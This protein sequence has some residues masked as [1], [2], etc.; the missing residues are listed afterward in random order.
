[1][2]PGIGFLRDIKN[3]LRDF[4]FRGLKIKM[5]FLYCLIGLSIAIAGNAQTSSTV[6]AYKHTST[7]IKTAGAGIGTGTEA[8]FTCSPEK[9]MVGEEITFD[10]SSSSYDP[11]RRIISYEWDFG[12]GNTASYQIVFHTYSK[13]GKYNITLAVTDDNG[14]TNDELIT[15]EVKGKE[16]MI[17]FDDG[18]GP[19][20][21]PYILDQLK[22]IK[23]ADGTPVK[24]G[25]FLVGQDKSRTAYWDIWKCTFWRL[26]PWWPADMCPDPGVISNPNIVRRIAKEGHFIGIHTQHHPDLEKLRPED[27]NSEI[28]DCYTAIQSAGVTPMKIFRSPY[29]HDP[30]NIPGSLRDWKKVRGEPT[31]DANPFISEKAVIGNCKKK[32]KQANKPVIFFFHDFRGLPS[33]R[34][35]FENIVNELVKEGYELADFDPSIASQELSY[36]ARH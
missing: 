1:M 15:V 5:A 31:G 34:F 3:K 17:T 13:S 24:A 28:I 29:L 10:A 19:V 36:T 25:F 26:V 22:N 27:V 12:D 23:K 2:T 14:L 7:Y 33:H 16:F 20:S 32:M 21:T 6:Q 11:N 9:P 8:S 35:N 18:P 30:R 4:V